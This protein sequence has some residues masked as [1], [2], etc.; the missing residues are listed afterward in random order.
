M[1]RVFNTEPLSWSKNL[2]PIMAVKVHRA[3]SRQA[4]AL[5]L[6][7]PGA[8][9]MQQGIEMYKSLDLRRYRMSEEA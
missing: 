1:H 7:S 9:T 8:S 2:H 4:Y 3:G 6:R 5:A